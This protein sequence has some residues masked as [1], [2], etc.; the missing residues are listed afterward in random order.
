MSDP[1]VL[2]RTF[3]A[4]PEAVY[5]LWTSPEQFSVWFGTEAVTVPLDT[6][7]L[8]VRVGGSWRA[9]MELP[10]GNAISWEGVYTE[11][12]PPTRLAFTMTDE[13]GTDPGAPVTVDVAA[14]QDGTRMTLTQARGDFSDEQVAAV[15]AGYGGFFDAMDALLTR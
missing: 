4:T 9:V 6:L 14:T 11:V 8:D 13:P 12:V 3:D 5:A 10:D 2:S 1:I 15:T 7:S